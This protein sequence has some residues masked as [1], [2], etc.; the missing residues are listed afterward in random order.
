MKSATP[1]S[2]ISIFSRTKMMLSVPWIGQL[3][4]DKMYAMFHKI[5]NWKVSTGTTGMIRQLVLTNSR[6]D[7]SVTT[8]Q[9]PLE[10]ISINCKF[11]KAFRYVW[12]PGSYPGPLKLT[13][14][15]DKRITIEA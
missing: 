9:L 4:F 14:L 5:L 12:R 6:I 8:G 2:D 15:I 10:I 13:V 7:E 1:F 3:P 11:D